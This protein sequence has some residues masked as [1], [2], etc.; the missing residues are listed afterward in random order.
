MATGVLQKRKVCEILRQIK[1]DAHSEDQNAF[2]TYV[3]TK[4]AQQTKNSLT[5]AMD[6]GGNAARS[7]I[8]QAYTTW[9]STVALSAKTPISRW[10][11]GGAGV[12]RRGPGG[13]QRQEQHG[14]A[15]QGDGPA[16]TR[17]SIGEGRGSEAG[18]LSSSR[19]TAARTS[20]TTGS[21]TTTTSTTTAATSSARRSK[22]TGG[23]GGAKAASVHRTPWHELSISEHTPIAHPDGVVANKI[24]PSDDDDPIEQAKYHGYIMA[25]STAA[26]KWVWGLAKRELAY[27]RSS[28]C[29][30]ACRR[31]IC[32]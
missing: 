24:N 12:D 30:P 28:S 19:P 11:D 7:S 16:A 13:G 8:T 25:T 20:T 22:G 31:P 14:R 10:V 1:P 15:R 18:G 21:A 27:G 5:K 29:S 23:K 26:R 17:A 6:K 32:A 4:M 9:I 2:W 3:N